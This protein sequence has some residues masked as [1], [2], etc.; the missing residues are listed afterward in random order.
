MGH[1][2]GRRPIK[3]I[4]FNRNFALTDGTIRE[5]ERP[6]NFT[7]AAGRSSKRTGVDYSADF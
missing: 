4:P 2:L 6:P 5:V 3:R 1:R 7:R